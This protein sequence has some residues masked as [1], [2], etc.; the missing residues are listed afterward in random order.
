[1]GVGIYTYTYVY[2]YTAVRRPS[3]R[4]PRIPVEDQ[5]RAFIYYV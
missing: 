3:P 1:M 4:Q 5:K 2:I